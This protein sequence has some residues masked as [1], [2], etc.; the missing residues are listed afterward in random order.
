MIVRE[1]AYIDIL[2]RLND[3]CIPVT[4][5]KVPPNVEIVQFMSG[6]KKWVEML[7]LSNGYIFY[8]IEDFVE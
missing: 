5:E 8:R 7:E 6:Q 1:T 2:M 4:V 3:G